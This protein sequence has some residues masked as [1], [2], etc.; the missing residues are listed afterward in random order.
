MKEPAGIKKIRTKITFSLF[1]G[2]G[3]GKHANKKFSQSP[4]EV[5]HILI[6]RPNHRLGNQLLMT[7]LVQE[8]ENTFP[9]TKID[10][11]VKGGASFVL[12]ENH[13]SVDRIISLPKDHFRQLF[14]Y[15]SVW[16]K[17]RSRRYDL[18]VNCDKYSSSGNL[19]VKVS[20]SGFKIYGDTEVDMKTQPAEYKHIS[21]YPIYDFRKQLDERIYD[22]H[23]QPIPK[24][25]IKL[26]AE[27]KQR[28]EE[29]LKELTTNT[30][31]SICIYTNATGKKL[32]DSDWW[33]PFYERL[34]QEFSGYNIV[35]LLPI[36]NVSQINFAAPNLYSKD[37]REMAAFIN[38]PNL[39]I[40]PD[41]GT[42]HLAATTDTPV[43]G[44]FKTT[45]IDKYKPY[46]GSNIAFDTRSSNLDD[47][48]NAA[49]L[50][51]DKQS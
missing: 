48:I 13:A 9:N 6:S 8:L 42:M 32:Y 12:F 31:P 46:G 28:G 21:K 30:R 11:F 5:K 29:L 18:V 40:A 26:T 27:E 7:P 16:V 10:L 37:L 47:W 25:S 14:K 44:F 35:E 39:F 45:S 34:K 23:N 19:A 49:H 15:L 38:A 43:I 2:L 51:L 22:N 36:E 50:I 4:A 17:L 20:R 33:M 41:N 24:L 1:G 3:K